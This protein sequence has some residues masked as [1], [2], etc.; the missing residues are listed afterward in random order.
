MIVQFSESKTPV[1]GDIMSQCILAAI[2]FDTN[3]LTIQELRKETIN[4]AVRLTHGA[5]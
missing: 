1:K 4:H 5:L 2:T 3:F